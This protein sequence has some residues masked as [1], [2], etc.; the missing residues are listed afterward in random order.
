MDS[1]LQ[2]LFWK[3]CKQLFN[4]SVR[5]ILSFSLDFFK[6][7]LS[8]LKKLKRL[9]IP[10]WITSLPRPHVSCSLEPPSYRE[11]S[12]AVNRSKSNSSPC[13]FDQISNIMFKRC[14]ILRSAVH[15]LIAACWNTS[16]VPT[17]WKGGFTVSIYKK[18]DAIDPS[19]FRLITLQR[20]LYKLLA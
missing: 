3:A 4:Q 20:A 15:K 11:V 17:C 6:P 1:Q 19:N 18:D 9:V 12:R 8:Q 10:G 14:P 5:V 13:P 16:S 2:Q 7:M